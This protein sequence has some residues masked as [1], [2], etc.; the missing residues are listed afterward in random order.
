MTIKIA[1]IGAGGV[2]PYHVT[3]FRSAG[4]IIVALV[5]LDESAAEIA[6]Q[7]YDIPNIY[8]DVESMLDGTDVDAVSITSP[9]KFH[10][11]MAIQCLEAGKHVFCEKPPALNAKEVELMIASAI[12]SRKKLMFNF[13]NRAWSKVDLMMNEI[14][15]GTFGTI[16][17]TQVKWI[18]KRGIPGFG[19]W[20]TTKS[21]SGGGALIDLLHIVDLAMYFMGYPDPKFALGQTFDD[22]IHDKNFQGAWGESGNVDCISDVESSAHGF[23]TFNTGQV[24]SIHTSWAEMVKREEISVVFQG[25]SGGGKIQRLFGTDGYDETAIDTCEMYVHKNGELID[26]KLKVDSCQ[27]MGRVRCASNFINTIL[28]E[29]K[30]L[31]TP[32]QA[33]CLMRVIDAIYASADSSMPIAL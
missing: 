27:D 13:N 16:N 1:I 24:V 29:E 11:P 28:G 8:T 7:K 31:S 30:P 14:R 15:K 3:G 19:G 32:Q 22:F 20:F 23:V 12:K 33:L 17:S 9:N 5:D 10:S 6:A 26:T 25:S 4:A 21:L 18:R 2:L